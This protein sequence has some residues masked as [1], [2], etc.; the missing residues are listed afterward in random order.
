LRVQSGDYVKAGTPLIE[1]P[2]IPHDILRINGEEALEEYLLREVQGVYR[3]QGVTLDDKHVE[4]IVSQM[5]KKVTV[6]DPGDSDLLPG[7]A[8]NKFL[9]RNIN[10]ELMKAKKKPASAEP[11][12]LGITKAS[13]QSDSMISA[14]SFQETTKVLTEAALSGKRDNLLGLKENV[15]LGHMVPTGTGFKDYHRTK[16]VKAAEPVPEVEEPVKEETGAGGAI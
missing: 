1:G 7:S 5:L 9:F 2:L 14:A 15:I 12:L 10:Q 8:V 3:S 4:I 11:L 13:L 6:V 16:V